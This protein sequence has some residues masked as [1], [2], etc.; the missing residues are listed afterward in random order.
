[1]SEPTLSW[2]RARYRVAIGKEAG[3]GMDPDAWDEEQTHN[4]DE[5]LDFALAE[6][7]YPY[8]EN[9]L[10]N[11]TFL[12]P[13]RR[14]QAGEGTT[15][16]LLPDDFDG[17]L[18]THL[19]VFSSEGAPQCVVPLGASVF[20]LYAARPSE[21]GKPAAAE[22]VRARSDGGRGARYELHYFPTLDADI[23]FEGRM[24]IAAQALT[25]HRQYIYGG[26][27]HQAT[28]YAACLANVEKIIDGEQGGPREAQFR[29]RLMAS[30]AQDRR[31]QPK[32]LGYNRDRSDEQHYRPFEGEGPAGAEVATI[33]DAHPDGLTGTF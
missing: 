2:N 28:V 4:V 10:Y 14:I 25:D 11:W 5:V 26:P 7:Y 17:F 13:V 9:R 8:L 6:F 23:E 18:E 15:R 31:L 27:V 22:V 19:R 20:G 33:D 29:Q 16:V 30:I 12:Q 32:S 24:S 1:M 21:T 3:Y